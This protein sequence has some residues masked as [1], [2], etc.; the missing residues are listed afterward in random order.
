[1]IFVDVIGFVAALCT[2]LS[3]APQLIKVLKTGDTSSLS[4]LMYVVFTFG[5]SLWLVYGLLREDI[6]LII[7]NGVTLLLA[8]IILSKKI[9]NDYFL[10]KKTLK[11]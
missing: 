10:S 4:L 5:V 7:A 3:F 11:E 1:M 2:T 8:G 6:P 9:R